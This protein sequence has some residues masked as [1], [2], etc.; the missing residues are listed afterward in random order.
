VIL[1]TVLLVDSP[2]GLKYDMDTLS[3]RKKV[4]AYLT[5]G[6]NPQDTGKRE[7]SNQIAYT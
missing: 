6:V 4:S 5:C 7:K 1:I 2:I 3:M